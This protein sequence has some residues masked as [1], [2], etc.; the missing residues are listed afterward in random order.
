MKGILTLAFVVATA[1]PGSA[2]A[3]VAMDDIFLFRNFNQDARVTR[4]NY[5]DASFL[6]N[7]F[8]FVTHSAFGAG[9][10][11]P[12]SESFELAFAISYFTISPEFLDGSSGLSDLHVHGKFNFGSGST[13]LAAGAFSSVPIGSEDIGEGDL[14]LG[15]FVAARHPLQEGTVLT[16][17]V[18][19]D[20]FEIDSE[21][22]ELS[23]RFHGG[24]IQR[25]SDALAF[26]GE[27]LVSTGVSQ[28]QLSGG[29]DLALGDSSH[30]RGSLALGL[31]DNTA[32]TSIVL[33]FVHLLVR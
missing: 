18:S 5:F 16:G 29:L 2:A 28:A 9:F 11:L 20:M 33:S 24:I 3:Q 32:D 1:L 27:L 12:L 25:A 30:L 7:S 17:K 10:G 26:V 31:N 4:S 22:S 6:H 8:E 19:A 14:D 21:D 23:F 15:V 13:Q